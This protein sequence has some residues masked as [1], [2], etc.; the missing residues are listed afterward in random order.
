MHTRRRAVWQTSVSLIALSLATAGPAAANPQGGQVVAGQATIEAPT[1]ELLEIHQHTQRAII[2]WRRF[3]IGPGETTRFVQ[4]NV[5]A[6]TLNRVGGTGEPSLI[7]GTLEANGNVVIVNPDGVH[8]GAGSRVDV[9]RLIATTADI[10]NGNFMGG[11]LI[12]DQPGNPTASIVNEGTI[13]IRD[14]GLAAL[15]APGVRNNGVIAAR[16]GTVNLAAGNTFTIDPYGDGLVKLTIGD[17]ITEDV[18]DVATG[19]PMADL[20]KNEGT[21]KADGGTVAMTAATARQ[22]VNSVINNT[23]VIEANTVGMRGGK[24][25]LGAQ[26]A[27][28]KVE[29]DHTPVQTVRVSGT[30]RATTQI[31]ASSLP[32]PSPAPRG[33]IQITGEAI[34]AQNALIDVSGTYG[35]GT[36]LIGGDYM[37]GNGDPNIIAQYNIALEAHKV[38]TAAYVALDEDV[39]IRADALDEGDGGKVIVWGDVATETGATI[40][41]RG[42]PNGGDGGFIE[43][44]GAYLN[45]FGTVDLAAPAGTP[46]TWLL[47]PLDI[48]IDRR[49]NAN[50]RWGFFFG[51]FPLRAGGTFPAII[52]GPTARGSVIAVEDIEQALN[53]GFNVVITTLQTVGPQRGD[54][55]L[56]ASIRKRFGGDARLGLFAA[57]DVFVDPGVS[58]RSTSGRL[59]FELF[60]GGDDIRAENFG[61]LDLNGGMLILQ[62]ADDIRFKTNSNIPREVL[63]ILLNRGKGNSTGRVDVAFDDDTVDFRYNEFEAQFF[64]GA[65]NLID[66]SRPGGITLEADE[67]VFGELYDFAWRIDVNRGKFFN[68]ED[69]LRGIGVNRISYLND[70][71]EILTNGTSPEIEAEL[72]ALLRRGELPIIERFDLRAPGPLRTV[73]EVDR[74]FDGKVDYYIVTDRAGRDEVIKRLAPPPP[75]VEQIVARIE[76]PTV[77]AP[78]I[79]SKIGE[80]VVFGVPQGV[81]SVVS[82]VHGSKNGMYY[83]VE[84]QYNS[85]VVD[86]YIDEFAGV[87]STIIKA[88]IDSRGFL[89]GW[90][91][92]QILESLGIIPEIDS[93]I[94]TIYRV[95]SPFIFKPVEWLIRPAVAEAPSNL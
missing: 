9:N 23:G 36:V 92:D 17:E 31:A 86:I 37:G 14:H 25:V 21:L 83:K 15:V 32:I 62:A 67:K 94:P 80:D 85:N 30:L 8:F 57:D 52:A 68:F 10:D 93:R 48:T 4:P 82:V 79:Q 72:A 87:P 89:A 78:S 77:L 7:L 35:G 66:R 42:G 44:S 16:L 56:K 38:P 33:H 65:I 61:T 49:R 51:D 60:A 95:S 40:S 47:D 88:L 69:A 18:I 90:V 34:L 13:S 24:I 84:R 91:L 58:V 26:T 27:A 43:T 11:R 12:F 75:P 28:T 19:Q 3:N 54:I 74:T 71:P 39:T 59:L 29:A 6:W 76:E 5:Q 20:V 41:A 53:N 63:I 64:A 73:A 55:Y 70:F 46:G 2:D 81:K 22:A 1:P 50:Q 45:A